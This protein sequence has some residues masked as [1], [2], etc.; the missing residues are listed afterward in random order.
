MTVDDVVPIWLIGC[1]QCSVD[2]RETVWAWLTMCLAL[3]HWHDTAETT[4]YEVP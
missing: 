2:K 1:A 4:D 3:P